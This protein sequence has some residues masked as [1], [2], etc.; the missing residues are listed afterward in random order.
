MKHLKKIVSI[1]LTAV[2]VL[3]M[4]ISVMATEGATNTYTI[5]APDT[6]HQYEIYQIFTGNLHEN[7]LSNIKWGNNGTGTKG[8]VV[9]EGVINALTAVNGKSDKEKLAV[10]KGYANLKTTPLTIISKKATY[11]AVAGYYLIKDVDKSLAGKDESYTT[12]IVKVHQFTTL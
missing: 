9:S 8:E 11:P 5:T 7:T 12:Y 4:C 6:N 2:M 3:A 10:I 1:L